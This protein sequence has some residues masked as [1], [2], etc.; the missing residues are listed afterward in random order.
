M[1]HLL[2]T[3]TQESGT[4]LAL[5][6]LTF[7]QNLSSMKCL[8]STLSTRGDKNLTQDQIKG[9]FMVG[10]VGLSLLPS[11][12][13]LACSM[14]NWERKMQNSAAGAT[15]PTSGVQGGHSRL[16]LKFSSIFSSLHLEVARLLSIRR[17]Q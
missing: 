5:R 3:E 8:T 11:W 16:D 1:E 14:R 2:D 15:L 6:E 10:I 4:V 13:L 17:K 7:L 12:E 9:M